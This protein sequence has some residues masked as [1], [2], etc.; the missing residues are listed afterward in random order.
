MADGNLPLIVREG[1]SNMDSTQF[2]QFLITGLTVGSIYSLLAIGFVT[3]Y[4]SYRHLE[5]CARRICHD[6]GA[7]LAS[8]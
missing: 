5:F 3:I 4:N 7:L 6:R 2:L 8:R 1:R